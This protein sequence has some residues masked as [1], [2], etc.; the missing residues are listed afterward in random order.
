MPAPK[1]L[2]NGWFLALDALA[3]NRALSGESGVVAKDI[4]KLTRKVERKAKRFA[5]VDTGRLQ[6]SITSAMGQDE[7]LAGIVGSNVEY[8]VHV[9]FGTSRMQAQSYLRR[10]LEEVEQEIS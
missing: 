3:M 6:S 4:L 2:G 8:A 5:P 7:E 1:P 10:A 9:E